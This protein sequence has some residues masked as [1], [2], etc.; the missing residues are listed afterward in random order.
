MS[1][2]FV[3]RERMKSVSSKKYPQELRERAVR[4]VAE[5][6]D[7]HDSEWAAIGAVA[8]LLGIGMTETVRKWVRQAQVDVGDRAGVT[9]EESAEVKLL[10]RENAELER[11]NAILKSASPTLRG[12]SGAQPVSVLSQRWIAGQRSLRLAVVPASMPVRDR[13][14]YRRSRRTDPRAG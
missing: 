1:G 3:S 12:C 6:R 10:R 2:G 4:M 9:S 5:I 8:E 7:Q 14:P 11:A 13:M